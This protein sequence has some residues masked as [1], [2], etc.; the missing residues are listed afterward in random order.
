MLRLQHS[1][2][3]RRTY[4]TSGILFTVKIQHLEVCNAQAL[5]LDKLQQYRS[6]LM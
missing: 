1:S 3:L 2:L 5:H 4:S 6:G